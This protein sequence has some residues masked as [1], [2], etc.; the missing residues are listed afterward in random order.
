MRDDDRYTP[1]PDR[2]AAPPRQ[3]KPELEVWRLRHRDGR[4]RAASS[5]TSAAQPL[6]PIRVQSRQRLVRQS[7]RELPVVRGLFPGRSPVGDP[8]I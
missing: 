2:L 7:N 8:L 5:A 1:H 4:N 3:P 6:F